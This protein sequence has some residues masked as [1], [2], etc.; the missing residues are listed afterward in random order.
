MAL[1]ARGPSLSAPN[2]LP[3]SVGSFLLLLPA[4]RTL[5]VSS[6]MV[7]IPL[8][9][10]RV[11]DDRQVRTSLRPAFLHAR[12]LERANE[13]PRW[14]ACPTVSAGAESAT[15]PATVRAAPASGIPCAAFLHASSANLSCAIPPPA[16]RR[17][18]LLGGAAR[19]TS[20]NA[21][22]LLPREIPAHAV[23]ACHPPGSA[24]SAAMHRLRDV[25]PDGRGRPAVTPA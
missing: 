23:R 8:R 18:A 22:P 12:G 6:E 4:S 5:G 21:R 13:T 1:P 20:A 9:P 3:A 19:P 17:P 10:F 11:T 15:L 14:A 16:V 25:L 24:A 2:A 7:T